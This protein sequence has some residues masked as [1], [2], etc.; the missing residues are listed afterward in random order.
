MKTHFW[1]LLSNADI[2]KFNLKCHSS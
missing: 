1:L 2:F